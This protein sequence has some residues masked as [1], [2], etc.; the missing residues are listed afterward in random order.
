M[1]EV[2]I[3]RR[4]SGLRFSTSDTGDVAVDGTASAGIALVLRPVGVDCSAGFAEVFEVGA[5]CKGEIRS[6]KVAEIKRKGRVLQRFSCC[7][8]SSQKSS[9]SSD[10]SRWRKR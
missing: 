5:A 4:G 6:E 2:A 8:T 1:V 7:C 10:P 9:V 3:R